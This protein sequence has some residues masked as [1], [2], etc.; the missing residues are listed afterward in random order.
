MTSVLPPFPA[1]CQTDG[2]GPFVDAEQMTDAVPSAVVVVKTDGMKR[3]SGQSVKLTAGSRGTGMAQQLPQRSLRKN[4]TAGIRRN[5][6]LAERANREDI[7]LGIGQ[8]IGFQINIV[9]VKSEIWQ[10]IDDGTTESDD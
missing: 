10:T 7:K 8:M 1:I 5:F 6:R 3:L 9:I 4:R 2:L